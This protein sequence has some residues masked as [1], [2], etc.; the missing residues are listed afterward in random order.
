M[1]NT[2][3]RFAA[4][5]LL[6]VAALAAIGNP[7]KI[8]RARVT[9]LAK[10]VRALCVRAVD[11]NDCER[12]QRRAFEAISPRIENI[13]AESWTPN[14]KVLL[15]CLDLHFVRSVGAWDYVAV[16]TCVNRGD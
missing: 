11:S 13:R 10:S 14:G 5:M 9:D 1:L 16:Q 6:P 3:L 15:A 7:P 12:T 4:A 8:Q 2:T